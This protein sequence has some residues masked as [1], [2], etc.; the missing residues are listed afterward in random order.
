M[1]KARISAVTH[2][3]LRPYVAAMAETADE[4]ISPAGWAELKR[5]GDTVW[6]VAWGL[7]LRRVAEHATELFGDLHPKLTLLH[8]EEA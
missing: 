3:A 1:I 5:T 8:P 6:D 7:V 4:W 2:D